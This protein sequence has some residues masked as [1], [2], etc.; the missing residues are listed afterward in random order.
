MI[1]IILIIGADSGIFDYSQ[2]GSMES[3]IHRTPHTKRKT[4]WSNQQMLR[5]AWQI[6]AAL[7]DVHTIGGVNGY[8]AIAHTDVDID[9]ILWMDGMFKASM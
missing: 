8:S 5:Y 7:K 9:Q 2:H 4:I 6:S 1:L 3:I